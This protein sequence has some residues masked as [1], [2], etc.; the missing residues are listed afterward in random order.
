[1][2]CVIWFGLFAD[3]LHW[4]FIISNSQWVIAEIIVSNPRHKRLIRI[5]W[6][7]PPTSYTQT[8]DRQ[9]YVLALNFLLF[10]NYDKC[11]KGCLI[12]LRKCKLK[13]VIIDERVCEN[14]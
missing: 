11:A 10:S 2:V 3:I 6:D 8:L 4:N 9:Y 13:E 7:Q 12:S 14:D 1:M 5:D